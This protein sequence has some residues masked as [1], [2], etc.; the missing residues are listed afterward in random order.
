MPPYAAFRDRYLRDTAPGSS[1]AVPAI[2]RALEHIGWR[3]VG[4]PSADD[5]AAHLVFMFDDCAHT[6]H[7][8][9]ALAYAI[10]D[11]MRDAGP[12]L[13]GGLPPAEAYL[14]AAEELLQRYVRNDLPLSLD[15]DG[16]WS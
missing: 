10:A 8:V 12:L 5:M 6:H 14:P 15:R 11:A 9:A 7:D 1:G 3:S 13:D 4:E 16:G 2:A